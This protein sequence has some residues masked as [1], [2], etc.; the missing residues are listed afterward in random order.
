MSAQEAM[1]RIKKIQEIYHEYEAKITRIRE[2]QHH[3]L[4]LAI[5]QKEQA[6]IDTIRQQ[7]E[8]L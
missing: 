2:E 8:N 4:Q 6:D 5:Q 3:A 7:I 1:E